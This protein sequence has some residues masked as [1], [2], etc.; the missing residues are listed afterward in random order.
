ML[1]KYCGLPLKDAQEYGNYKSCPRCS[2][3][4][5][6]HIFYIESMFGWTEKRVTVNNPTGVQSWCARCRG[7]GTGPYADGI[8]CSELKLSRQ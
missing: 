2:Q 5:D 4:S 7:N 1:C 3:N 8:K 6:E